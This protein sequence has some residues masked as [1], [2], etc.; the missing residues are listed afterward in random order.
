M[1]IIDDDNH[2]YDIKQIIDNGKKLFIELE[3]NVLAQTNK[4]KKIETCGNYQYAVLDELTCSY[5]NFPIDGF[6]VQYTP[7]EFD[8]FQIKEIA[9]D[10]QY[11]YFL[12][13]TEHQTVVLLSDNYP[14]ILEMDNK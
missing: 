1:Q 3:S 5:L 7:N 11:F 12:I 4:Q 10:Y 6:I 8:F 13:N 2:R 9:E 14:I